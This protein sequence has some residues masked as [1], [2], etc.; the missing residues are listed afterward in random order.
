MEAV[1]EDEVEN[2]LKRSLAIMHELQ[3]ILG[4]S[5]TDWCFGLEQPS[6]LDI[7]LLVF[8][9]RLQ[10]AAQDELIPN[11]LQSWADKFMQ[12]DEWANLMQGTRTLP[13]P[14]LAAARAR[15]ANP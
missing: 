15:V 11:A 12:M 3:A 2:N 10:D 6:A 13:P 7:H 14:L 9:V 5:P 1:A 4:D 8:L